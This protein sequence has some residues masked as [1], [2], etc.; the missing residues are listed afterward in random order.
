MKRAAI[1]IWIM[2]FLVLSV[3]GNS[4]AWSNGG[5]SDD[6]LNPDYGTHDWI[7]EKA[8][9]MLPA[10]ESQYILDNL[11]YYLYGTELPD[12]SDGLFDDGIGDTSWHHVYFDQKGVLIDGASAARA[13]AM[14]DDALSY[15][16][17]QDYQNDD[18]FA[19]FTFSS[20]V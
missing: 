16:E 11:D 3:S 6:I 17:S 12:N 13:K 2:C 14:Y 1:T 8:L 18:P 9:A 5:Y 7:A 19:F 20:T 15:L 4:T 10:S